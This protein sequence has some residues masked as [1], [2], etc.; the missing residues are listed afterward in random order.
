MK[1]ASSEANF[2][3]VLVRQA[4]HLS[5]I[6]FGSTVRVGNMNSAKKEQGFGQEYSDGS[7]VVMPVS[8]VDDAD[9]VDFPSG[10]RVIQIIRF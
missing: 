5:S 7:S 10:N 9:V 6:R 1:F 3:Y 8:K 2:G 4:D